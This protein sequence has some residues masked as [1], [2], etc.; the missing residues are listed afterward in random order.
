MNVLR[1]LL[2]PLLV[3]AVLP[4]IAE[5]VDLLRGDPAVLRE[6]CDGRLL[7]ATYFV[8]RPGHATSLQVQWS[9]PRAVRQLV[10]DFL[11]YSGDDFAPQ[12]TT[13][14]DVLSGGAWYAV[15]ATPEL[16][17]SEAET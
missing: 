2:W 8:V 9:T 16:D 3:V 4:A 15:S 17:W 10:F 1:I 14:L 13:R 7:S 6:L 12:G 5:P 11:V